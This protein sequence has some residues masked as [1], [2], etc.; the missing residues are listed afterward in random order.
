[1]RPMTRARSSGIEAGD[2]VQGDDGNAECTE[3]DGRGVRE[4]SE[5]GCFEAGKSRDR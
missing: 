3:G 5:A 4:Q 2:S 1:M